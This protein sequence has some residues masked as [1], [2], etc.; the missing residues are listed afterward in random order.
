VG[1][2]GRHCDLTTL[3]GE[4]PGTYPP[5]DSSTRE[6]IEEMYRPRPGRKIIGVG[7]PFSPGKESEDVGKESNGI[8]KEQSEDL[9]PVTEFSGH[10]GKR[11]AEGEP[12][13]G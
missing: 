8:A 10:L 6:E 1:S 5:R 11:K 2:W 7:E 4:E 3:R 12:D 9:V 13:S